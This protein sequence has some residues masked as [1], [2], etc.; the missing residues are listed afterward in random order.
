MKAVF[1]NLSKVNILRALKLDHLEKKALL[2]GV[3]GSFIVANAL[4]SPIPLRL[5]LSKGKAYTL[6]PSTKKVIQNVDKEAT[7]TFYVSE[8]LP[9]RFLPLKSQITD[10]LQEYKKTGG[11]KIKLQI[12]D[13]KKDQKALE[14]AKAAGVPELQFSQVEQDKYAVTTA[15]FGIVI[16]H[17]DKKETLAQVTEFGGLEYNITAALYKL[18]RKETPKIGIMGHTVGG[19]SFGQDPI[20]LVKQ[21]LAQQ[22]TVEPIDISTASASNKKDVDPAYNALMVFDTGSKRYDDQELEGLRAYLNQGGKAVFFLDQVIVG[23]DL[24]ATKAAHNLDA[25]LGEWG[26]TLNDNLILSDSSELVNFGNEVMSYMVPYPLWIKTD[27]L[28]KGSSYFSN[29]NQ[30]LYAWVSSLSIAKKDGIEVTELVKTTPLSWEQKG[31]FKLDPQTIPRPKE[32]DLKTFLITAEAQN[33]QGGKIMVIPTSRFLLDRFLSSNN[34]NVEVAVNVMN[35]YAS[36]G[37]LTGIRQR[38]VTV[39]P[40]PET[41]MRNPEFFKYATMLAL[42]ILFVL[43]GLSRLLRR[44]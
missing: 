38:A 39:Y 37:A 42:P 44:R 20:S 8:N 35:D 6:S 1:N 3:L 16:G 34:D 15:F 14:A 40:L 30:L 11:S 5:D 33:K 2:V 27:N 12:V 18:T 24:K 17:K 28:A 32:E 31:E 22:F 29:V 7:V 36:G 25:L 10:L 23:D 9:T 26:I 13:P 43:W 19:T 4:L 21:V 41:A